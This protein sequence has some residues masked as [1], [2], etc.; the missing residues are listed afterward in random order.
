MNPR[1]RTEFMNFTFLSNRN[2]YYFF[3]YGGDIFSLINTNEY[4]YIL[5]GLVMSKHYPKYCVICGERFIGTSPNAKYCIECKI[6]SQKEI[7]RLQSLTTTNKN[8]DVLYKK[9][10]EGVIFVCR[11]CGRKIRVHERTARTMCNECLSETAY[12]RALMRQRKDIKE[13]VVED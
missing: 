7:N 2:I 8:H 11:L 3:D 6:H 10:K 1:A 12:G 13:E 4:N 9:Y 5:G